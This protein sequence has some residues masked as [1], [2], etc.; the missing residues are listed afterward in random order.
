MPWKKHV[1]ISNLSSGCVRI[2]PIEDHAFFA[3]NRQGPPPLGS[4]VVLWCG[5]F[6]FR[7]MCPHEKDLGL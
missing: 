4:G 1:T 5:V 6:T 7:F 2:D 3:Q